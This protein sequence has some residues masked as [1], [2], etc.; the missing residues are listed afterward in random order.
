MASYK[1][2]GMKE[3]VKSLKKLEILPQKVVST[4]VR[5]AILIPK[6]A[7]KQG[8]WV[9][10]TGYMRKGIISKAERSRVKG[11]KVYQV[12]MD[13][14]MNDVFVK[15][16]KDGKKRYYYPAS[17]EYG[18]KTGRGYTPGFHFMRKAMEDNSSKIEK[19]MVSIMIK[20][21]DK[22]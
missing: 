5:K 15:M 7:V 4:A 9:D 14:K 3:L 19:E 10:Q 11:K 2:E 12:V 20:E 13:P 22:I 8:E 21:I 17:Q 6:A 18:F 16:S 1:I